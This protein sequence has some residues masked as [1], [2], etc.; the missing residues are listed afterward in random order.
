MQTNLAKRIRTLQVSV[1][2]LV[3]LN[4]FILFSAFEGQNKKRKF[5]EINVERINIIESD[6]KLK[7]T[8][9]NKRKLPNPII[10]GRELYDAKG[11]RGPGMI[12]YNDDGDEV[13]GYLF[14]N[15]GVHF[16]MDQH[17]QDQI[18][19]M[20]VLNDKKGRPGLAGYWVSPQSY[21]MTSDER[22]RILDSIF[23]ISD[24]AKRDSAR[25]EFFAKEESYNKVFMGKNREEKTGLFLFDKN[26]NTRLRIYIDTTGSPKLEFLNKEG[27]IIYTLPN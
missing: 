24:K 4:C 9:A 10:N 14:G 20:Q 8:L 17:K 22:D 6:G 23:A 25:K 19:Y 11:E 3:L 1:I 7:M 16:S 15:W 18:V 12:F 13:G 26:L 21:T 27:N 5:E 2:G